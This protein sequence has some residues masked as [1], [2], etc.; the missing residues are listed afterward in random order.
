[1]GDELVGAF[2]ADL[3]NALQLSAAGAVDVR[4]AAVAVAGRPR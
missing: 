2:G 3:G 4:A 1:V